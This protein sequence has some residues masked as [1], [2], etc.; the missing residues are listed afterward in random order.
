MDQVEK[1]ESCSGTGDVEPESGPYHA[2]ALLKYE[3]FP[4][5]DWLSHA[6]R[7]FRARE[8]GA[9]EFGPIVELSNDFLEYIH[10]FVLWIDAF[11]PA[12]GCEPVKGLCYYGPTAIGG[13]GAP[14]ARS[15]FGNWARLLSSSPSPS[16]LIGTTEIYET[17]VL[18]EHGSGTKVLRRICYSRDALVERLLLLESFADQVC[19]SPEE[20]YILHLG[21]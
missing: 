8:S 2:F 16:L 12:K 18:S 14:A 13:K 11:N 6:E 1:S 15:L 4:L 17:T 10:D 7:V 20:Y 3:H 9:D 5:S 21:I 19:S